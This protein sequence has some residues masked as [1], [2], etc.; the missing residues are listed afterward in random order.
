M[1]VTSLE[2]R[3]MMSAFSCGMPVINEWKETGNRIIRTIRIL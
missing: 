1:L 3:V 2:D